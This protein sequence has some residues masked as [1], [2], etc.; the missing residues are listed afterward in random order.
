MC[1]ERARKMH[2]VFFCIYSHFYIYRRELH[3]DDDSDVHDATLYNKSV[4]TLSVSTLKAKYK[5][6]STKS[7]FWTMGKCGRKHYDGDDACIHCRQDNVFICENL[8]F[9]I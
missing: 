1:F 9:R 3:D 2:K 6:L 7:A 8:Y 4:F 5:N